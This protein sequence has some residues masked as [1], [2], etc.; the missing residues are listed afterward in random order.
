MLTGAVAVASAAYGLGSQADDGAAVARGGESRTGGPPIFME[1]GPGPGF[2]KLAKTLGVDADELAKALRDF[3]EQG[4]SA[5][6]D[7]FAT[8][9][10]E[11]L[12]IPADRVTAAFEEIHKRHEARFA[13]KLAESLGVDADE[14]QAALDKVMDQTP[15]PPDELAQALADEL[16]VDAADVR[17]ALFEVRPDRG[18]RHRHPAMPLRQLAS[19]LDVSRAELRTA[20]R[21]VRA[22]AENGREEHKQALAKFL[23][24]RFDLDVDKVSDAL[25]EL[26]RPVPPGHGG[27]PGPGGPGAVGLP[28]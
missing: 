23:A 24:D 28:L 3:H 1:R 17:K 11:A 12:G 4:E 6:R 26:P 15:R 9:L 22:G 13:A 2:Q 10:A 14:V 19:A 16:G 7:G 5:R 20:L 21:E 18:H 27:R 8:A 25:G